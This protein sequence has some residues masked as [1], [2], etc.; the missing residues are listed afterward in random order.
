MPHMKYAIALLPFLSSAAAAQEDVYRT[1]AV[2]NRVQITFPSGNTLIG[3]LIVKPK[4][5]E[6]VPEVKKEK[7]KDKK[8]EAPPAPVQKILQRCKLGLRPRMRA[9]K[10]HKINL[11][12]RK[13]SSKKAPP[14][15]CG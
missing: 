4:L 14:R 9:R 15:E 10:L 11:H 7:E 8:D 12:V 2:G 1:L 6:A 13:N 3:K 5:D